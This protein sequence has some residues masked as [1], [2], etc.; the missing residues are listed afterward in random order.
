MGGNRKHADL[1][2]HE[3]FIATSKAVNLIGGDSQALVVK[4]LMEDAL[5]VKNHGSFRRWIEWFPM[6]DARMIGIA[7]ARKVNPRLAHSRGQ[8]SRRGTVACHV[9]EFLCVVENECHV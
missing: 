3:Y 1:S 4:V 5:V 2:I 6:R 8:S 7:R 9:L